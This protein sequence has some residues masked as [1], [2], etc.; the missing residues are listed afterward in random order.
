MITIHED[1]LV[2]EQGRRKAVVVSLEQWQK[3]LEA[4]EELED[5]RAYD[6]AKGRPSEPAPLEQA[7]REIREGKSD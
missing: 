6:E 1:Y 2:D 4:L 3:V 7:I 5:I